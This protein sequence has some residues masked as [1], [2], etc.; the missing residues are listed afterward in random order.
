MNQQPKTNL[1]IERKYVIAM[2]DIA[3]LALEDSYSSSEIIQIY[4]RGRAGETHRVRR[5]TYDGI[6]IYTETRKLRI[7][8][9]SVAET[10]GEISEAEFDSLSRDILDG[11]RPV[12]KTRHTFV[13]GGQLFEIDIYPEWK[14]TAIMETE[15]PSRE[16]S[17]AIPDFIRIIREVT[18]DKAY[19]N[20]SMSRTF[21]K[22]LD[23]L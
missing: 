10:E 13:S 2:P 11:T 14:N 19:S 1:E 5:R 9:M 21:P 18:G 20:A 4:L 7:D 17:V 15:L 23:Y 6:S 3:Q 8:E 16:T 12:R 22:E